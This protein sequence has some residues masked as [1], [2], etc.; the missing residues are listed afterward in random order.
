MNRALACCLVA[1]LIA[2]GP[3][4]LAGQSGSF[5][6]RLGTDTLGLE[7][8]TRTADRLEG[9][10][11]WRAPV[12]VH[13]LFTA[14]FGRG[15]RVDHF[16]LV[17]HNVTGGSGPAETKATLDF[18][19][20]SAISV[21]PEGDSTV[22]RSA[23]IVSG[24]GA[25]PYYFQNYALVEEITRRARA[26]GGTRY[27]TTMVE[28]GGSEPWNVEVNRVGTDSMT[29][30]LG[31]IGPLRAQ[32]DSAG[33]LLGLSGIGS[34]VQVTVERTADLDLA[35]LGKDFAARSLGPLSPAD[36]VQ[37][38]IGDATLTVHYARP[39]MRG[40]TIFG[41]V[42]PWNQ[43]WRTGANEATLLEISADLVIGGT[44]VPAGKY[45]LWTIPGPRG[46]KLIINKN[47]GQWGTEYA[48]QHDLVRL[49]MTVEP[50]GRPVEQFTIAI[51]PQG[52]RGVLN[53]EWARTRAWIPL[54]RTP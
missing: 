50:L 29:L 7:R 25:L 24:G 52:D 11:V 53:L 36:S 21:V 22:R 51:E 45:S 54:S 39:S 2:P 28:L 6:V 35:T 12:T 19:R 32:V 27:R 18:S 31:P 1:S 40:R 13:R 17:T 26:A 34:T 4:A 33:T 30:M 14:T 46:W 15:G 43:V 44:S 41:G 48:A 3:V 23:R 8:Y 20:D 16:E 47:T 42:V 37:A 49:D 5:V 9:E 10:Q 38:T